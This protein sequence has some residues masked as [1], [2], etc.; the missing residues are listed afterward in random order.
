MDLSGPERGARRT[1]EEFMADFCLIAKR[2][3]STVDYAVFRYHF[4]LGGDWRL[5]C[6]KLNVD[7]KN[8]FHAVYRIEQ[9]LGREFRSLGGRSP[10]EGGSLVDQFY[11]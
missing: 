8:F 3:L 7:R 1:F 11:G 2:A 6:R 9:K 10:A 5:C 4:L